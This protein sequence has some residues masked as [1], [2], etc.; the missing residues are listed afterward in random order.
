MSQWDIKA[1]HYSGMG[2]DPKTLKMTPQTGTQIKY[3]KKGKKGRYKSFIVVGDL[4]GTLPKIVEAYEKSM[5]E[6]T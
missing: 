6:K 2:F 5:K 4:C 1:E 3:R